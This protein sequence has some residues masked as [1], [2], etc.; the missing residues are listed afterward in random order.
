MKGPA[1]SSSNEV[2]LSGA[3]IQNV[4]YV[5]NSLVITQGEDSS[6]PPSI[7]Q[8]KDKNWVITLSADRKGSS[9]VANSFNGASGGASHEYAPSGGGTG[10]TPNELNFYFAVTITFSTPSGSVPVQ[11][12]LAQGHY[13][14]TNN[15]W[16]GA[17]G[18]VNI[19]TPSFCA[20]A[21]NKIEQIYKLGGGTSN[22]TFTA[23][24]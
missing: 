17:N 5:N 11:V 16:I 8:D 1:M 3:Q 2:K 7:Q 6:P 18:V 19:G 20:I 24:S 12:N 9:T 13:S 15:W 14:T 21:N 10:H 4:T 23:A 22:F